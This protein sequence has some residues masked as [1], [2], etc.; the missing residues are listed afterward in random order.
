MILYKLSWFSLWISSWNCHGDTQREIH[1]YINSGHTAAHTQSQRSVWNRTNSQW[2]FTCIAFWTSAIPCYILCP[3]QHRIDTVYL[4]SFCFFG[5]V[6]S[7]WRRILNLCPQLS[8]NK[9]RCYVP[10]LPLQCPVTT[11]LEYFVRGDAC[12][13]LEP[14]QFFLVF[15]ATCLTS[16]IN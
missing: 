3:N 16:A 5:A 9:V 6:C 4:K 12:P 8:L 14:A 15:P 13:S 7:S 1:R 2:Q 11:D 10:V